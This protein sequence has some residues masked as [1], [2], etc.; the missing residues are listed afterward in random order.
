M[1]RVLK[2]EL[3]ILRENLMRCIQETPPSKQFIALLS[4]PI[5]WLHVLVDRGEEI[6]DHEEGGD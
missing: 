1:S 5:I 6:Q 4:L 2:N 3:Q